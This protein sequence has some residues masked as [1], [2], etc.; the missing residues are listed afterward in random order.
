MV[1][2]GKGGRLSSAARYSGARYLLS[3]LEDSSNSDDEIAYLAAGRNAQE[4]ADLLQD[5]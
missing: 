1:A 3:C 4:L 5:S 2:Q